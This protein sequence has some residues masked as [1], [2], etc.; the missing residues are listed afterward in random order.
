MS[1]QTMRQKRNILKKTI[2]SIERLK[3]THTAS[4]KYEDTEE[5]TSWRK[6]TQ[7]DVN[8]VWNSLCKE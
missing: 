1:P 4:K 7:Q 3:E 8:I 6:L 2:G 5:S